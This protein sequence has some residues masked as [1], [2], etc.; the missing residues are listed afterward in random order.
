MVVTGGSGK[1]G[2]ELKKLFP[3]AKFP[4]RAELDVTSEASMQSYFNNNPTKLIVHCA[5][6]TSPPVC[7]KNPEKALLTNIIGTASLVRWAMKMDAK[8]IY[9]STEYVFSGREGLYSEIDPV[10]PVNRYAWSKLGG[11][12]AVEMLPKTKFLIIRC[13]FGPCPF[14][15]DKAPYDQFT[16]REPV[17][18]VAKQIGTLIDKNAHGIYHIGGWRKSVF[19]YAVGVSPD[20]DIRKCSRHDFDFMVP[21][22]ASLDTTK[23]REFTKED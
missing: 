22:D 13:A 16:S 18:V 3:N 19:E 2:A 10:L 15:Y 11:E 17:D 23:Y 6:F 8:L 9:I 21:K 12:C 20:K 1:L 4:G 14:P 5:A 7:E